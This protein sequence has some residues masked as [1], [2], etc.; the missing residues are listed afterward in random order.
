MAQADRRGELRALLLDYAWLEAKLRATDVNALLR[1][2][3]ALAGDPAAGLVQG[4]LRLSA[5]VLAK[6]HT[7]L[8]GQLTGRLGHEEDAEVRALLPQARAQTT[9]P[10]LRPLTPSLTR[11]GGPLV[12]T[13]EGH[14]EAV[15]G[16]AVTPDG[17]RA[18]SASEDNTL[19]VWDLATC[20]VVATFTADGPVLACAVA[21][22]GGTIV[23]G[24]ALG[25][26]HF[27]RLENA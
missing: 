17:K 21:P 22:D 2:F 15:H 4:A 13:L 19:K 12:R 18:I 27:L 26:L 20:A 11:A 8:A 25:R 7:Q 6:D 16:V 23:A 10:W 5:H 3:D 14:A 1:D 24:D 9:A